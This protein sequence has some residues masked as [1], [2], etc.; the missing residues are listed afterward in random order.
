M[1]G[2]RVLISKDFL[3]VN[4]FQPPSLEKNANDDTG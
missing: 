1:N 2:E 4:T 3:P